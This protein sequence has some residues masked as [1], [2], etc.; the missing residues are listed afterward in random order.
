MRKPQVRQPPAFTVIALL[1]QQLLGFGEKTT[2]F[3]IFLCVQQEHAYRFYAFPSPFDECKVK[4]VI[5]KG[6]KN[7]GRT[8]CL[9]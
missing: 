1:D 7:A 6:A 9:V 8:A 3:L 2:H 4:C 5:L